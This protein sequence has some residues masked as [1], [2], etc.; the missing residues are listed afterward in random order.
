MAG[1][2]RSAADWLSGGA[3][4]ANY[5]SAGTIGYVPELWK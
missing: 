4:P 5:N 1:L 2:V 3:Y